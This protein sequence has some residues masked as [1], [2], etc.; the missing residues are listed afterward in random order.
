MDKFTKG[1]FKA[2]ASYMLIVATVFILF[3]TVLMI[4]VVPSGSM[5]YT[6]MTGDI[7]ISTQYDVKKEE[8]IHRY[9]ILIFI[10]PDEPDVVYVKRVIGLPGETVEVKEGSVYVDGVEIDDSFVKSPMNRKGDGIYEVPEGC[11][12]FLGDNRN[13]SRDSRFWDQ[14]YVPLENIMG[15]VKLILFPFSRF[16][17]F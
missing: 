3:K 2:A 15:K 4:S 5:E 14:K 8:D 12:F 10:P 7:L 16:E 17:I 11:Y 13:N 6:I 9:D 1:F